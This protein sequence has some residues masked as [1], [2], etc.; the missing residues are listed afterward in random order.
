VHSQVLFACTITVVIVI[1]SCRPELLSSRKVSLENL[2]AR[3]R[4]PVLQQLAASLTGS[5]IASGGGTAR[6]SV[7]LSSSR[8][9]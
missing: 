5:L 9:N 6:S 4:F 8:T 3:R 1:S 2:T 7:P